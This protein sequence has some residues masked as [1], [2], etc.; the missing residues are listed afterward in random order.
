MTTRLHGISIIYQQYADDVYH[1]SQLE[2]F[3]FAFSN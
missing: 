1:P 2:N 3:L